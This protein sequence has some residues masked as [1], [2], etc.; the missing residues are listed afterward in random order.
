MHNGFKLAGL[1]SLIVF[2]TQVLA[3]AHNMTLKYE[4]TKDN[5]HYADITVRVN[6]TYL[7]TDYKLANKNLTEMTVKWDGQ[8]VIDHNKKSAYFLDYNTTNKKAETAL[9]KMASQ[10]PNFTAEQIFSMSID[11]AND[12]DEYIE[13]SKSGDNKLKGERYSNFIHEIGYLEVPNKY[14]TQQQY[15]W[16]LSR[17]LEDRKFGQGFVMVLEQPITEV[18]RRLNYQYPVFPVYLKTNNFILQ[19]KSVDTD[20][21]SGEALAVDAGLVKKDVTLGSMKFVEQLSEGI[22]Q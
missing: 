21:L 16:L 2:N 4:I 17:T 18:M 14:V 1:V 15:D 11:P 9:K 13:Y 3:K 19:L 22:A 10:A 6:D 20:P 7:R 5:G 12:E 8:Y